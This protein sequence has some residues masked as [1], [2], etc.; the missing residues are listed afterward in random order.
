MTDREDL[1]AGS[2]TVVNGSEVN[3]YNL[4]GKTVA[5]ARQELDDLVF[6]GSLRGLSVLLNGR[7][8]SEA[9]AGEQTVLRSGD[10]LTFLARGGDKG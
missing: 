5:R 6:G 10:T 7:P 8:L 4:G 9:V 3:D 1:V 2:V